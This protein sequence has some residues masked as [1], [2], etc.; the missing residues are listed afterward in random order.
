MVSTTFFSETNTP[1][2][3]FHYFMS[4][5]AVR[6][7]VHLSTTTDEKLIAATASKD[8]YVLKLPLAEFAGDP[9][10]V[11]VVAYRIF[12][13]DSSDRVVIDNVVMDSNCGTSQG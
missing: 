9:L 6:L 11:T 2:L 5:Y 7:S 10:I 13:L 4:S 1:C 8:A 3:S 12:D